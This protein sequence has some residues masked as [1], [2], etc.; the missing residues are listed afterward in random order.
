MAT[1]EQ[2]ITVG[3]EL[4]QKMAKADIGAS[5][6]KRKLLLDCAEKYS[7]DDSAIAAILE[8]I[9][10]YHVDAKHTDSTVRKAK[11][12]AK[13]VFDA[14]SK[15]LVSD[16]NLKALREM[17]GDFNSFITAA[18]HLRG[19][20]EHASSS[21][22]RAPTLTAKQQDSIE[23]GLDKANVQ[24]IGEVAQYAIQK[25]HSGTVAPLAGVQSLLLIQ[26]IAGAMLKNEHI[27]QPIKEAAQRILDEAA[28][29]MEAARKSAE[30]AFNVS[31]QASQQAEKIAA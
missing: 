22:E 28:R 5:N 29:C 25:L 8:G 20:R 11:S 26:S 21:R 7:E 31:K 15:T 12:E 4:A 27:E 23:E 24:Q 1:K 18:R 13:A 14:V 17:T 30:M 19:V 2:L 6:T 9:A 3:V 10:Q 16:D